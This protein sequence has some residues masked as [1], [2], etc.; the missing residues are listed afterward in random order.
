MWLEKIIVTRA[1]KILLP[2]RR[3]AVQSREI[4]SAQYNTYLPQLTELYKRTTYWHGTGRYHYQHKNESRYESVSTDSITDILSSILTTGGLEPH[5]DPW[6]KSGGKT[7]SLA[8]VRMHARVFARIHATENEALVYELGTIK[9]WL[10]LYFVLL[11]VW[12]VASAWSHRSFVRHTLRTSFSKDVQ[13]WAS[14]LRTP[15]DNTVASILDIFK[16]DIP[17]S[18]IPGN[19]PILIGITTSEENLIDT[20]PLTRKVEQRSLRPITVDTFTHLEVPLENINE[21]E[22]LLAELNIQLPVI[23]IEFSDIYLANEP[24]AKLAFL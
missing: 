3:Q 17:T 5:H 11:L 18:D 22:R 2:Y 1:E 21:T 7:V 6:I 4:F 19:Y 12:L 20:I 23:P 15:K 13:S 8:T 16:G 24:L 14:A 10:R 9:F